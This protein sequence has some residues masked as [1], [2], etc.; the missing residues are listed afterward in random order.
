MK[1]DAPE[2][3]LVGSAKNIV[4]GDHLSNQGCGTDDSPVPPVSDPL[5]L[6]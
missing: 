3:L 5:E 2:L 4:L 1:Y 6:W